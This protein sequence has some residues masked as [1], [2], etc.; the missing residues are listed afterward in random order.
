MLT[1]ATTIDS[2]DAGERLHVNLWVVRRISTR[3]FWCAVS[4]IAIDRVWCKVTAAIELTDDDRP[5]AYLLDVHGDRAVNLSTLV[6]ATEDAVEG[7]VG[8]C[9]FYVTVDVGILG[10]AIDG[11]QTRDTSHE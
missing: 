6:V 2:T 5:A 3:F 4:V 1:I 9:Q 8:D 11:I 7:T 10:T